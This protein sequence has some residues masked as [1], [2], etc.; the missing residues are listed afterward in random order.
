MKNLNEKEYY[1]TINSD[2]LSVIKFS[3]VWCGPCRVLAPILQ[4]VSEK[5]EDVNFGEIDVDNQPEIAREQSVRSV[6]TILF[7]KNGEIVNKMVG[8]QQAEVYESKINS[9]K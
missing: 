2:N 1:E 7:F 9:L 5:F 8:L 6:P 4:S 3:G